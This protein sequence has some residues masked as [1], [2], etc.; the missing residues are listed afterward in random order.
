MWVERLERRRVL[1]G[2]AEPAAIVADAQVAGEIGEGEAG[3]A[4]DLVAFARALADSGTRMYGAAWSPHCTAQKQL[5]EDG[6]DWLPFVEVTNLDDPVTL[7]AIGRGE[8]LELNPSG[9][10]VGMFPTWEFPDGTRV[11]GEMTLEAIAAASDVAI[12]M[13]DQPFIVPIDDGDLDP[14]DVDEDGDDIVTL[15]G[16]SPLHLPLDGYDPGGGM[17]TYSVSSS[18][19]GLVGVQ[20]L[21]GN[22]SMLVDVIGWGEMTLQLFEQRA[23][24]PTSRLIEL[25]EAD[26]YDG[27]TFHRI[28]NGFVI[29]GGDPAGTGG[30][31][32][33]LGDFDD[34]F[35]EQL[36]HNRTGTLSYAK[37][38]D[39]TNDSQFFITEGAAGNLRA[40][41]GNHSVSGLLVEGEKNRE[42]ISNNSANHP[43]DVIMRT[44]DIFT[45][46]ENAVLMLTADEDA[47][48]S[49]EVTVTAVDEAGN[50][51][52][53]TFTVNVEPD[54]AN[55]F[56]WLDEL[57]AP[58]VE[59]DTTLTTNIAA[60]DIEGDAIQF[61][62]VASQNFTVT[63][64][65]DPVA[66]NSPAVAE[67]TITPT[68]G[69]V[70][71]EEFTFYVYDSSR[72]DTHGIT[73]TETILRSNS[74][75][76]D[77]QTITVT[78]SSFVGELLTID[79]SGETLD[80]SSA[81][82][83]DFS[84][85]ERIDIVGSGDNVL[86]LSADAVAEI[87]ADGQLEVVADLGDVVEIG[88]GWTL[89]GAEVVDGRF[90]RVLE[91]GA[92]RLMLAGPANYQ[93]P[94]NN[95]DVN[96]DGL[97]TAAADV[98]PL[99]NELNSPIVI[100]AN[101]RFPDRPSEPA[102]SMMLD[103]NG[104]GQL[105]AVQDVLPQINR[106]NAQG[107]GEG[108]AMFEGYI[109]WGFGQDE[110]DQSCRVLT[111]FAR[112]LR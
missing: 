13:S 15:L 47:T 110:R 67:V 71:Q 83:V 28:V 60:R 5:F 4:V 84:G 94:V 9:R 52:S 53:R 74:Q 109:L 69:F 108:E 3:E 88:E 73:I 105:T 22:R 101:G 90:Y 8:D 12:P 75:L 72:V 7:N 76:F 59:R 89:V 18:D 91:Q 48:G 55:A 45:D 54:P 107:I 42:A 27:V 41:D 17:L 92:V 31:G 112:R 85:L 98:L 38:Y 95:G 77:V 78:A 79:G 50:S 30:G 10:P 44:V 56:P 63:V 70:G 33:S 111:S 11:V 62:V 51:F 58:V 97:I 26:F 23:P 100:G 81:T 37:S 86:L 29:Q 14:S 66:S 2:V 21:S 1:A 46:D 32:S 82:I 25:A 68:P 16:G 57:A 34:Q 40:L 96:N 93:N 80:L 43:V 20:L 64:P 102:L 65:E 104:D 19:P 61:G 6:G 35:H 36:Q 106:L 24:R 49:A 99:I 87:S 103:T 39:D